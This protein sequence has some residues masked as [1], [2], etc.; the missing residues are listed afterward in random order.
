MIIG[1]REE[2]RAIRGVLE[3]I[4]SFLRDADERSETEEKVKTWVAKVREEAYN[5]EDIID[6]FS[7]RVD[8]QWSGG[9]IIGV[10]KQFVKFPKKYLGEVMRFKR[11]EGS[12]LS[13]EKDVGM[14]EYEENLFDWLRSGK[15]SIIS[16]VGL[17]GSGKTT[18]VAKVYNSKKVKRHFQCSAWITVSRVYAVNDLLK[19]TIK[20]LYKK[21]VNSLPTKLDEMGYNE[22]VK[23]IS[24]YLQNDVWEHNLEI[25]NKIK[26][27]F[28]FP[29]KGSVI[30]LTT[31]H[32]DVASFSFDVPKH[33][34]KIE[35][36][37]ENKAW[38][39]FC[40]KAFSSDPKRRCPQRLEP[41]ARDLVERCRGLPLTIVVMGG[42]MAS[43]DLT[44]LEW[45]KVVQSPNLELCNNPNFEWVN[46]ILMLSIHDLPYRLKHCCMYCCI[47]P[48]DYLIKRKKLIRL[49]IA[50]G[51]VEKIKNKTLEDV[52][53]KYIEELVCRNM[54]LVEMKNEFGRAKRLQL[55]DLICKLG[56]LISER[57]NFYVAQDRGEGEE[58]GIPPLFDLSKL[59]SFFGFATEITMSRQPY[60]LTKKF[61]FLRVLD[62]QGALIKDL[63]NEIVELFSLRYLNLRRTGIKEV[64]KAL[65]KLRHLQTLD[66]CDT[67]VEALP[68][69]AVRLQNLR[70]LLMYHY[71]YDLRSPES[72]H[73]VRRTR[74][75]F[76]ISKLKNLQV[77]ASIEV[78]GDMV[79]Q[80]ENMTQLRRLGIIFTKTD[81]QV[82]LQYLF[83]KASDENV[84]IQMDAIHAP[85]PLLQQLTL[86]GKLNSVWFDSLNNLT[87]LFLKFSKLGEDPLSRIHDLPNLRCLTLSNAYEGK[88]LHFHFG[89]LPM[90]K[91]L[92]LW[93]LS[94]LNAKLL[95]LPQGIKYLLKLKELIL[96]DMPEQFVNPLRA[97]GSIDGQR[98]AKKDQ[99]NHYYWESSK[100]YRESS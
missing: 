42:L 60:E 97:K 31:R 35:E 16:V 32:E 71:V 6:E 49:W 58:V 72:F 74:V 63:P 29:S 48:E 21:K 76:D 24:D 82:Q 25:W 20:Q 69:S 98:I 4:E 100:M 19:S 91:M 79:R 68:K 84:E 9:N 96:E 43:K 38:E 37:P 13:A 22:P 17:P 92:R 30:M 52:A 2:F 7:C 64:P 61:K 12:S 59:R 95:M 14:E 99:I 39:L 73:F 75:P 15:Q 89:C 88:L 78:D 1:A 33:I 40:R 81:D 55:H 56:L 41:R 83:I 62:L 3:S 93:N 46:N 77:L 85:P 34:L 45:K 80:L 28:Q 90:L 11:P 50:E 51:F 36:L 70:N 10:A 53:D 57:E 47:F 8:G 66:V 5:I 23:T 86:V 67:E 44:E 26:A 18:I 54:I 65:A 87:F 27:A 94:Q